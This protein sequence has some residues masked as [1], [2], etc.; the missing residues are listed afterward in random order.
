MPYHAGSLTGCL[1]GEFNVQL[2]RVQDFNKLKSPPATDKRGPINITSAESGDPF[3]IC[4]KGDLM[5][6]L[7]HC[8]ASIRG[9]R[10]SAVRRIAQ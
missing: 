9:S 1:H 5:G 3:H 4:V 10:D 7:L 2:N 8:C 6:S